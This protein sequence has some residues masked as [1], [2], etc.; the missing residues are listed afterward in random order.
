MILV[1]SSIWI[2]HIR[3]E[4][5]TLSAL[6]RNEQAFMHPFVIGEVALGNIKNRSN[7]LLTMTQL[8][9]VP[10]ARD[11]EVIALIE[12]HKIFG[13]G[14]GYVDCHL[15]ASALTTGKI[16]WSRD[17]RLAQ[18]ARILGVSGEIS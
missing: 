13:S 14:L 3:H 2:D 4:E 10:V 17:K 11:F 1:D 8:P 15:L 5:P 6:L 16:I 12:R 18:V 9:T 7:T